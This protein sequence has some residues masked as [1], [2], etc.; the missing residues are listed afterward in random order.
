MRIADLYR[1][2]KPVFSFELL[3]PRSDEEKPRLLKTLENLAKFS[4][5]YVSVTYP[6]D[7]K[8]RFATFETVIQIQKLFGLLT[9]AHLTCVNSS[10]QEIFE[11]LEKLEKVGIEN[12]LALRGD[13]IAENDVPSWFVSSEF[14]FASD[15]VQFIDQYFDFCIGGSAHPEKHPESGSMEEDLQHLAFKVKSGCNFLLTQLFFDNSDYFNLVTRAKELGINVPIVPGIMP[16]TTLS[17]IKRILEL[18]GSNIPRDFLRDLESAPDKETV[19]K[20]GIE[21]AIQQSIEL[22][23][24]GAAGIHFYTLNRFSAVRRVLSEIS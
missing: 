18:N 24:N 1:Q 10:K 6:L 2:N 7:R 20:L 23:E 9:M 21:F 3:P 11:T 8:R 17:G 19:E 15:L 12:I 14:K 16:V 5:D 22:L 13:R 4:P